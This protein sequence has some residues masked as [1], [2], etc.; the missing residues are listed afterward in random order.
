MEQEHSSELEHRS[1][2][3][4]KCLVVSERLSCVKSLELDLFQLLVPQKMFSAYLESVSEFRFL[5]ELRLSAVCG[6]MREDSF[7][8]GMTQLSKLL[9]SLSKTL[10]VLVL[11]VTLSKKQAN[12]AHSLQGLREAISG[13]QKLES[14]ELLIHGLAIENF[15]AG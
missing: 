4:F 9:R 5:E 1:W 14:L 6:A 3:F 11:K 12:L 2:Y 10:R 15:W 8:L 7:C 13:L